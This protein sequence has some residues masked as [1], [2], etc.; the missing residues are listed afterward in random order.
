MNNNFV[1]KNVQLHG[2]KYIYSVKLLWKPNEGKTDLYPVS[3][4]L[5]YLKN[6]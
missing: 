4:N 6:H 5:N 2:A 3:A 1:D